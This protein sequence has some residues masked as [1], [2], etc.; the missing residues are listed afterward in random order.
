MAGACDTSFSGKTAVLAKKKEVV[1]EPIKG[2]CAL[3]F[4]YFSRL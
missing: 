4:H 2:R 3:S 1:L